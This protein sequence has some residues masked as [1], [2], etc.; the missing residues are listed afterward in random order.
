[1]GLLQT[2]F[3]ATKYLQDTHTG[4]WGTPDTGWTESVQNLFS[5]NAPRTAQGGSNLI[6]KA[7]EAPI[8]M[9][10]YNIAD[11]YQ[12]TNPTNT[13]DKTTNPVLGA[14]TDGDV[15]SSGPSAEQLY[16]ESMRNQIN[17]GYGN[18]FGQ[19]DN[20]LNTYLPQQRTAQEGLA[21]NSY[22]TS[23]TDLGL[24]KESNQADLNTQKVKTEQNQVKTLADVSNNIRNLMQAGNTYLGSR[25][26]GDSSAVNQ[27]AYALTKLGSQQRGDVQSQTASIMNDIADREAKLGNIYMQEKNRLN[28]ELNT[29]LGSIAQWFAEQQQA[30]AQAKAN[31]ELSK[32]QDLQALSTNLLNVAMQNINNI[33]N[34]AQTKQ[35]QLEEWAMNN[36][37]TLGELKKNMSSIGA[38][39]APGLSY[40]QINGTPQ[41][42]SS[43]NISTQFKGGVGSYSTDELKKLFGLA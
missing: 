33:Q 13:T 11:T 20:M 15:G 28:G 31:G 8:N 39:Q 35:A 6:V 12:F 24:Q 36:S 19:L 34:Q 25:G 7:A 41:V 14:S 21:Q 2:L 40:S 17:S 18:Y 42:D 9:Q 37:T 43:G 4:S 26:A 38:F 27:Y 5:P 1:M 10:P 32:S 3:P 22:N 16:A 30:I 29:Q 23:L